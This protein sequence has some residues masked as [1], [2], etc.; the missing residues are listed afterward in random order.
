MVLLIL[1]RT[2]GPLRSTTWIFVQ[3]LIALRLVMGAAIMCLWPSMS[4]IR[5]GLNRAK[6]IMKSREGMG[7]NCYPGHTI[8]RCA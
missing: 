4:A 5:A 6:A 3:A 1:L 2:I 8:G 7:D